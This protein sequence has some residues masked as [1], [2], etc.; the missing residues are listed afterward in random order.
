[1]LQ[2]WDVGIGQPIGTPRPHSHFVSTVMFSPGDIV[3]LSG[4]D[5]S[6]VRFWDVLDGRPLGEPI[7][8]ER[9]FVSAVFLPSGDGVLTLAES[10]RGRLWRPSGGKLTG[11]S[12]LTPLYDVVARSLVVASGGRMAAVVH[13]EGRLQLWDL[14]AGL[15]IGPAVEL[16]SP[17][18]CAAFAPDSRS[19]VV[20]TQHNGLQRWNVPQAGSVTSPDA[21]RDKLEAHTGLTLD[22]AYS[23]R[24]LTAAEWHSRGR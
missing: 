10:G 15:P 17:V 18:L 1:V 12:Q 3:L 2:L 16:A 5:D 22:E 23:R 14:A 19:L 9:G 8:H 11:E 4:S 7:E 24:L 6:Y 21:L 20:F 13:D